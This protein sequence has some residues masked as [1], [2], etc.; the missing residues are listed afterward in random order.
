[1]CSWPSAGEKAERESLSW[2]VL[3]WAVV[4]VALQHRLDV[5]PWML[6][7]GT[8]LEA[9]L[10]ARTRASANSEV[11]IPERAAREVHPWP[12]GAPQPASVE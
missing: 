11:A 4:D 9:V 10:F 7:V 6:V 3:Y 2:S 8:K 1:M 5:S 12:L